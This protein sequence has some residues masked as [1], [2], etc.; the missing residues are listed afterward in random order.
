[1]TTAIINGS[2]RENNTTLGVSRALNELLKARQAESQIVTLEH[3]TEIF[4]GEYLTPDT[5]NPAQ[6]AV[7]E[8]LVAADTL[9]FVVPTYYKSMPGALKNFFDIVRW[10]EVYANK[11]L[12]VIASNHKNQD[13]GARHAEDTLK[14]LLIFS[15][16]S[17][18]VIPEI[19]IIHPQA[20]NGNELERF[21][22]LVDSYP[23]PA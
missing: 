6:R 7:L 15:N 11:R 4:R 19:L 17:A 12:A 5:V 23:R 2:I 22:R 20:I 8:T 18:V 9:V 21:A 16:I 10:P 1:M 3:F 13:Y 14:G